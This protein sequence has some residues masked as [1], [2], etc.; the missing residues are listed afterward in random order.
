MVTETSQHPEGL[1][2]SLEK[3]ADRI[4]DRG[5]IKFGAFTAQTPRKKA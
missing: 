1:T 2:E 3:V 5:A 4:H